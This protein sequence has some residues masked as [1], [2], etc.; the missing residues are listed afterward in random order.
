M[1]KAVILIA[2]LLIGFYVEAKMNKT[3]VTAATHEQVV[4]KINCK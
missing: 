3:N 4:L 2:L 1:K